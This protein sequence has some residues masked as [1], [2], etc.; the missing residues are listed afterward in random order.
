MDPDL[1]RRLSIPGERKVLLCVLDGLGGLPGP[2]GR[3][4]L[5]SADSRHLDRLAT[6]GALGQTIPVGYGIT[7]GS[8]PGH[9]AL[10]GYD[11]LVYEVGR[12]VLEA[13]GIDIALRPSDLAARGNLC[14]VDADGRITDR[15]ASRVATEVTTEIAAELAAIELPGCEVAVH[16]VREHRFVL[17]LRASEGSPPLS[18]QISETDPQAEGVPPLDAVATAFGGE[19]TAA[20]VNQFA[21]EARARLAGREAA[22]DVLL[23]GWSSLPDLPQ[24]PELWKLRAAAIAVYPMYRGLA[25]LVGMDVLD[26]GESFETAVARLHSAWDDYDFFFLHFKPTDAAGEDGDFARKRQALHDFDAC[27]PELLALNPNVLIIAGDHSTPATMAAHSWHPVPLLL[28]GDNVRTDASHHFHERECARG[29]LGTMPAKELL[30]LA[31]AHAMR[32]T[33]FGA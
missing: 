23:R 6:D 29:G 30:P 4:E 27:L 5:E 24:L 8:G 3:S 11:P 12:G 22:N 20:L 33:K 28:W 31:F 18:D 32:L 2:L 26:A 21:R 17:V 16:A 1:I 25:R 10:F 15:R 7:P 9:L 19:H 13:T 14:T